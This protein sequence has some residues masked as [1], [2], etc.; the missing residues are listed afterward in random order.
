MRAS[1]SADNQEQIQQHGLNPEEVARQLALFQEGIPPLVI[2]KPAV[3]HD[4]I[5]QLDEQSRRRLIHRYDTE[6][7]R[8]ELDVMK[9]VPA[10][11]AATRMFKDLQQ[12]LNQHGHINEQTLSQ[13]DDASKFGRIFIDHITQFAFWSPLKHKLQQDGYDAAELL[14]TGQFRP[15]I[16]YTLS[17]GGLNYANLPKALIYFH[18]DAQS[19]EIK[20]SLEEHFSE[21]MLYAQNSKGVV[22]LHFT[23]SQ[24][25]E[26][27]IHAHLEL[28][29]NK[30]ADQQV[31]FEVEVSYQE[32]FTDT[33]AV[34]ENNEPFKDAKGEIL[35][36]PGGHGALLDNL[37]QLQA[38]VVFIKNID[39]VVPDSRKQPTVAWKKVLGGLL[40]ELRDQVFEIRENLKKQPEQNTI[41]IAKTFCTETLN[42]SL[43]DDF[44]SMAGR[45]QRDLLLQ[46]TDRPIRVCGMVKNEGEPGGGPFWVDKK[47][48]VNKLQIVETSQIDS[49]DEQ[50]MQLLKQSTHFNPVD[51][52]CS[53]T[54]AEGKAYPLLDFRDEEAAFI[55]DKTYE[56]RSLKALERPGLWNGGMANW[57]TVFVEVSGTTFNPVKTVNDLLRETH[58]G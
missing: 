29:K 37:N 58:Q 8:A 1:I 44:E 51:L 20:T 23:V 52:V 56:G 4:G 54:N 3:V 48:Y 10:S 28:I 57:I 6:L 31:R 7:Q 32:K 35:F 2:R 50:Q 21:G 40:V 33:I 11:G 19:G 24:E 39:N 30:Y 17:S 5:Q 22:K 34:D 27:Q 43:P 53:L 45:Q 25:F 26:E 38:D 13:Q 41:E 9:F 16:E 42:L 47:S 12:L 49:H 14:Q 18:K 36:R 15:L 46:L 55:T